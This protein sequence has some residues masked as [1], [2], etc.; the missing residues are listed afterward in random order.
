MKASAESIPLTPASSSPSEG[1]EVNIAGFGEEDPLTKELNG[2]LN[3]IGMNV[4]PS[5]EC[6]GEADALF[7]C[8]RAPDG[9]VCFGDSGSGLTTPLSPATLI[10]VTNTVEEKCANGALGGFANVAAPEIRDFIEGSETPPQ[11]PRGGA[12]LTI[13]GVVMAGHSLTCEPG[14]WTN[15]PT[16]TYTYIDSTSGEV[17]Q[18]GSSD[19]YSLTA[20]DVG[21]TILCEVQAANAG[22]TA[23]VRTMPLQAVEPAP[24]PTITKVDPASGSTAGGTTVTI[25]GTNLD[26]TSAVEFG[27]ANATTFKLESASEIIATSPPGS[28]TVDVTATTVG[29]TTAA[30]SA[31]HF[32]YVPPP[33]VTSVNPT[34]GS[35]AGGT[36]VTITGTNLTGAT[37]VKFGAAN[38]TSF[39]VE[40]ATEIIATSPPGSGAV[41]VTATTAGGTTTTSSADHFTYV[42]PPPTVTSI[43]PT[44]GSTAGGAAVTIKGTG[45][46]A[47]AT[48][49]IG[50]E[51][52]S[53]SVLSPGE[54]TATTA[55]T[56]AGADEVI[57]TD[58]N[59]TS[60]AGPKYTYVAPVPDDHQGRPEQ[61]ARPRAARR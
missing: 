24:V 35:T 22:G 14:S 59:G 6:G 27:A 37:A 46:V 9:S 56:A 53:V 15:S 3:L 5:Q 21:R 30:G 20:A 52:S 41:D 4:V 60:S 8:A 55:A 12:G 39:N 57:V 13:R 33:N 48:V 44:Q 34:Q 45:F 1:S 54:L 49:K 47:G 43:N 51:A 23:I 26:D 25:T 36:T 42:T 50:S 17:L 10:G 40:S 11:A 7:V 18:T 38:A 19:T 32:S 2:T 28:G 58:A 16:V 29:G 61:A 31:D